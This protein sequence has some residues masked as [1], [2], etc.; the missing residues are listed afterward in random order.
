[1]VNGNGVI[2]HNYLPYLYLAYFSE[3]RRWVVFR[4]INGIFFMENY[5]APFYENVCIYPGMKMSSY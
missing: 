4:F 5:I 3:V 1:M 2:Q